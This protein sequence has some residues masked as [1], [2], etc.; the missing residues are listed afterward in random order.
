MSRMP[1]RG[2]GAE[3]IVTGSASRRLESR[4]C[5]SCTRERHRGNRDRITAKGQHAVERIPELP[6]KAV[7]PW[8]RDPYKSF[9]FDQVDGSAG[10]LAGGKKG[11]VQPEGREHPKDPAPADVRRGFGHQQSAIRAGL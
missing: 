6:T 3:A 4:S 2:V 11:A 7:E 5:P 8:V 9:D 10:M 1:G